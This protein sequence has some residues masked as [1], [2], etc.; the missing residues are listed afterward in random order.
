MTKKKI[1]ITLIHG[2]LTGKAVKLPEDFSLDDVLPIIKSHTIEALAYYGA[3]NCGVPTESPAMQQL[4][5]RVCVLI[6]QS[7]NQVYEIGR[8]CKAFEEN[9]I[10]YMPVKGTIIKGWYD[11]PEM[12]FMSDADILIKT[13]QYDKIKPIMQQLCY[14]EG[15]ESE[16]ELIW[17]KPMGLHVELHK[18]LI[19]PVDKDFYSYFGT[20]WERAVCITPDK[21]R[22]ELSD[23]DHFIFVFAHF[24]RHYRGGGI[25]VKHLADLW[26]YLQVKNNMN[27]D[28]IAEEFKKLKLYDFY[29]N[30]LHT[31]EVWFE[32]KPSDDM[33]DLITEAIFASGAYGTHRSSVLSDAAKR[34]SETR[35]V[36][37]AKHSKKMWLIFLPY[38]N[39]CLKYPFL[40]KLPFL[41]PI[42][43]IVRGIS[44]VFFKK[45]KIKKNFDEV[46]QID[47][48]EV[49]EFRKTL[50]FVG[51]EF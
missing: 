44:A 10:D 39:M 21:T 14:N 26:V 17:D 5:N 8:L 27:T 3:L 48:N 36:K 40:K 20:G 25:G 32:N 35:S 29:V 49:E 30:I 19:P 18:S 23:E 6:A 1:I 2:A 15:P 13:E 28:Y 42:M 46:K 31:L 45:E 12:R 43:W 24:A 33:S 47:G 22:Y 9:G 16:C 51:L 41:L 4:F 7:N 11:K 34:S 50:E 37:D 38:K